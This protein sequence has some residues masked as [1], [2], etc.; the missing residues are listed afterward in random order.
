MNLAQEVSVKQRT[1]DRSVSSSRDRRVSGSMLTC[2]CPSSY[3]QC[4]K[5]V[6]VTV[7]VTKGVG[8]KMFGGE[9]DNEKQ[10]QKITPLCLHLLYQNYV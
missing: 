3:V 10:D 9:G 8:R 7:Y 2:G 1:R 6:L 4:I 5:C